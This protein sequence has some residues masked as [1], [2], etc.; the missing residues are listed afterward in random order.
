[1]EIENINNNDNNNDNN[2]IK[3]EFIEIYGQNEKKELNDK[4]EMT[5][6]YY[7]PTSNNITW[8]LEVFLYSFVL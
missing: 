8:N 1:M 6:H 2:E 5:V 7:Q 4:L 3:V